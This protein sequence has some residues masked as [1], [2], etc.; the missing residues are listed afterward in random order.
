MLGPRAKA[1]GRQSTKDATGKYARSAG[2]QIRR[3]NEVCCNTQL[4]DFKQSLGFVIE[5]LV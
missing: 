1:G 2:A 4:A 3:H 5:K